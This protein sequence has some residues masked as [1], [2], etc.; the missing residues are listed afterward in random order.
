VCR[1]PV[2]YASASINKTLRYNRFIM[3]NAAKFFGSMVYVLRFGF[4]LAAVCY[5]AT[6]LAAGGGGISSPY[7][8]IKPAFVV[9]LS[10]KDSDIRYLQVAVTLKLADESTADLVNKH[11]PMI[12]HRLVLLFSSL[13]FSAISTSQGKIKLTAD[14]LHEIQGGLKKMTGKELVEEVYLPKLVGQ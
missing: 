6:T 2:V 14:V 7:L 5:S 4:L 8:D 9:N 3:K 13:S 10:D 12:R 1:F 11:M